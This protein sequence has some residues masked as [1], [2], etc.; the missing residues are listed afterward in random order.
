MEAQGKLPDF[1]KNNRMEI[2]VDHLSEK[3]GYTHGTLTNQANI[4]DLILE[5]H[6]REKYNSIIDA[7]NQGTQSYW[8]LPFHNF[9]G[10]LKDNGMRLELNLF[11]YDSF[12]AALDQFPE[13]IKNDWTVEDR[14][15]FLALVNDSSKATVTV[16]LTEI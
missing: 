10:I 7:A 16:R 4:L 8:F 5:V 3:E 9:T 11:K 6:G 13:F 15:E 12:D 1:K 14:K 2:K